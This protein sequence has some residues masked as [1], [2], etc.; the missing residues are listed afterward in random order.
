[1]ASISLNTNINALNA[2][3]TLEHTNFALQN[4]LKHLSTGLGSIKQQMMHLVWL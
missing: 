1:M 4:S 3:A 2:T